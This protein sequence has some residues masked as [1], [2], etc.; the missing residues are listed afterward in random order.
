M[1][2]DQELTKPVAKKTA[3]QPKQEQPETPIEEKPKTKRQLANQKLREQRQALRDQIKAEMAG[4]PSNT[5]DS[6]DDSIHSDDSIVTPLS[7]EEAKLLM[8]QDRKNQLAK[9]AKQASSPAPASKE[10]PKKEPKPKK[11]PAKPKAKKQLPPAD[12]VTESESEETEVEEE[13]VV[14]KKAKKEKPKKK[15]VIKKIIIEDSSDESV[16]DTETD[17]D[18]EPPKRATRETKSQQHRKTKIA[19]AKPASP[20]Y[21]A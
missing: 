8:E 16:T 6:D 20:Y 19:V 14:V 21:F 18:P 13:I 10:K 15:K 9:L 12:P 3:K 5:V 7:K 17:E 1:D 4:K 2:S 11:A